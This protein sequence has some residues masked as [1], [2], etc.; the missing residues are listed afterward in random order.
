[1]NHLIALDDYL[2]QTLTDSGKKVQC[3]CNTRPL[4][5]KPC[6]RYQQDIDAM[7]S[8]SGE[9]ARRSSEVNELNSP[10]SKAQA[11][12][13]TVKSNFDFKARS[14]MPNLRRWLSSS[15]TTESGSSE[16]SSLPEAQRRLE[17]KKESLFCESILGLMRQTGR[18][19]YVDYTPEQQQSTADAGSEVGEAI[20]HSGKAGRAKRFSWSR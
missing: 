1:M 10:N 5:T 18:Y 2:E 7:S 12:W 15:R 8:S 9:A 16:A 14:S 6:S 17:D 13:N 3:E 19:D 4:W 11:A 20:G